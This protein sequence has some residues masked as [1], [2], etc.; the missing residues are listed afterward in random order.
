MAETTIPTEAPTVSADVLSEADA[1]LDRAIAARDASDLHV[2]GFGEVSVALGWPTADPEYVLK[3][4]LVYDTRAS[5][6]AHFAQIETY[7][8]TIRAGG[9]DVRTSVASPARPR[10]A[11]TARW[12][13]P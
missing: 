11:P 7:L 8:D 13:P 4:V 1:A 3:R 9:A 5:C 2:L 10:A 6:E 12:G